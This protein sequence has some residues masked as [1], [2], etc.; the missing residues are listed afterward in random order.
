MADDSWRAPLLREQHLQP[1]KSVSSFC[2][3][4]VTL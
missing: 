2:S 1:K 4:H 3:S